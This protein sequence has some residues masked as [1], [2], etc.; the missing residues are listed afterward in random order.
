[1]DAGF[2]D[3][4]IYRACEELGIGYVSLRGNGP[5]TR[6]TQTI[7]SGPTTSGEIGGEPGASQSRMIY[8]RPSRK[9]GQ[10]KLAFARKDTVIYTN[11]GLGGP[12][13][14]RLKEAGKSSLIQAKSVIETHHGRG[15]DELVHRA[16][17]DFGTERMP[18]EDF[19]QNMAFYSTGAS[20][21]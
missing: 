2:C 13:D 20:V 17:K 7:G 14:R 18:F 1:M 9:E 12:I 11:L 10:R 21:V 6:T 8:L 16:I 5:S 15:R 3:K 4:K 19:F